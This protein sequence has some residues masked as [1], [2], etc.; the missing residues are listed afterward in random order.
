MITSAPKIEPRLLPG[1]VTIDDLLLAAREAFA[2]KPPDPD[3][4]EVVS[5]EEVTIGR[6]MAH[7]R[8]EIVSKQQVS[9]KRLL[10]HSRNRV[11]V[12]VT[13]L[14]VL[15]LLKRR[16]VRVEQPDLFGD[17]VI[18]QSDASQLLS[19]EDWQELAEMTDVS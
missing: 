18:R 12:I 17:I 2:I 5:R 9:F 1:S 8:Q 19:E 13:L 10:I 15:E 7:I 6:Q 3:V 16:V 14:A 11:E 4:D